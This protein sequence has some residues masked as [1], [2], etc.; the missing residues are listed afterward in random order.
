ML[1]RQTCFG[2]A[3]CCNSKKLYA[4][5]RINEQPSNSNETESDDD[6]RNPGL[7]DAAIA[8]LLNSDTE[9]EEFDGFV[10]EE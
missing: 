1:S 8:Q 5:L 3:N 9:D 10:E 2:V 6:E 4:G 7:L